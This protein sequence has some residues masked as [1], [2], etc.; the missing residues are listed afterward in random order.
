MIT[1]KNI[2]FVIESL[3]CGGAEKSLVTLLQNIDFDKVNVDLLVTSKGVFEKFVPKEVTII[4]KD[5][6]TETNRLI[7]TINRIRYSFLR[8]IN[9]AKKYH[10][11][12]LYWKSFGKSISKNHKKYDISIAYNQGFATYYVASKVSADKKIT[13]LN[14]DYSRAGYN[15]SFDY[16]YYSKF[17]KVVCV[18]KENELSLQEV[19]FKSDKKLD[20]IIIKDISDVE[21]IRKM[22]LE[23]INFDNNN[24]TTILTVG[25]LAKAKGLHMA[26][27]ACKA[28]LEAKYNIKWYVIGDGPERDNLEELIKGFKMQEK[29]ILLGYKE[30]P[31]PYIKSCDVY[32]QTS[33]FEGLGLTVIEASL[34]QKAIVT[35]NFPTASSIINHNKTGLICEM[36]P[37]AIAKNIE[38]YLNNKEFK[39]EVTMNLSKV[40]N[41]DKQISLQ[42]FNDLIYN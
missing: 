9:K 13:W 18:S 22:S 42:K 21:L 10:T 41:N 40:I 8:K 25:R 27:E 17:E 16:Q 37:H 29:F 24:Q 34:L 3:Q 19:V 15:I 31:Y 36:T 32:V 38:K 26:I 14:T 1:K 20:T 4:V 33:L 11:A 6:F 7:N 2:L 23:V 35:T 12:Q 5:H 30:N 28:L 39:S